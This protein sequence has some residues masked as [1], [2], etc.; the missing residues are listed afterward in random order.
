MSGPRVSSFDELAWAK[1]LSFLQT[2]QK[3]L[4]TWTKRSCW[5]TG[6]RYRVFSQSSPMSY[7]KDHDDGTPVERHD[8]GTLFR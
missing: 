2:Q 1:G 8:T 4:W 7:S 6:V 5:P 3:T